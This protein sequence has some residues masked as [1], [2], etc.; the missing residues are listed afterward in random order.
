MLHNRRKNPIEDCWAWIKGQLENCTATSIPQ[1]KVEIMQLWTLKMDDCQYLR[2]LIES[3]PRRLQVVL[4]SSGNATKYWPKGPI[5]DF[6]FFR[7]KI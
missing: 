1:L 7:S 5:C 2:N 6:C 3:M 4:E